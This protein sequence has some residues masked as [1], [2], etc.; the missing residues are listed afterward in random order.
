MLL[1]MFITFFKIGMFTIGGGYAMLPIIQR[2]VV[3][4][5]GWMSDSEFLDSVSLT[6]SLPG[7]LATNAATFIGYKLRGVIGSLVSIIGVA[8]P[9]IIIITIIA[10][11]FK[12]IMDNPY[13]NF[14]FKGARPAVV[15]LIVFAVIKLSKAAQLKNLEN[16]IIALSAFV[17]IA[18]LKIHPIIVILFSAL[19]GIFLKKHRGDEQ[20]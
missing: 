6:N 7:P 1:D 11:L 8:S 3:E 14:I 17:A 5:K 4:T 10:M 20:C 16:A 12:N 9:S 18:F 2:E 15:A 13:V 19:Y